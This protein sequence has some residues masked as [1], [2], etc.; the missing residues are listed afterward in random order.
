MD[1]APDF[2]TGKIGFAG[3]T[4]TLV[5]VFPGW[6]TAGPEGQDME[7][8]PAARETEA[9][10]GVRPCSGLPVTPSVADCNT[11]S[12]ELS[13]RGVKFVQDSPRELPWGKAAR[14]TGPDGNMFSTM[15]REA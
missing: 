4:N 2:H 15:R 7:I 11:A 8:P 13:P 10:R 5:P 14:F 6:V 3:R 12:M 1:S 9:S